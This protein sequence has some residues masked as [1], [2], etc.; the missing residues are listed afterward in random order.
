M[1]RWKYQVLF[2]SSNEISKYSPHPIPSYHMTLLSMTEPGRLLKD[3]RKNRRNCDRVHFKQRREVKT[4]IPK[5]TFKINLSSWRLSYF[6]LVVQ[7]ES[8]LR[9]RG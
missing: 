1:K 4:Y 2:G 3:F 6:S 5:E 7:W 9:M 8:I